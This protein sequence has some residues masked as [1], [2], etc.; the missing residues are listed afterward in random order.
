MR[1]L[2]RIE[3]LEGIA[4][5]ALFRSALLRLRLLGLRKI[6]RYAIVGGP[7]WLGRYVRIA[8]ALRGIDVRHFPL[9]REHEAWTWLEAQPA[10]KSDS[11]GGKPRR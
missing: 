11:A 10:S 6:E 4:R 8:R 9:D 5:G 7:A 1:L 3:H 2:A